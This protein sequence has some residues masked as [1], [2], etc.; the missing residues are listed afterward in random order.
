MRNPEAHA[1]QVRATSRRPAHTVKM[2]RMPAAPRRLS[3]SEAA[4]ARRSLDALL[5]AIMSGSLDA[6]AETRQRLEGA[7]IAM[8]LLDGVPLSDV[9]DRLRS[10][11]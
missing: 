3:R 5:D 1:R 2:G 4:E 9:L 7:V 11:L 10:P 6:P 8:A